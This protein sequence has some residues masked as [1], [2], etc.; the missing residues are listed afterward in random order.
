MSF[1]TTNHL[2]TLNRE[3]NREKVC[4]NNQIIQNAKLNLQVFSSPS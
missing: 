3:E 4:K 2:K 1:Q